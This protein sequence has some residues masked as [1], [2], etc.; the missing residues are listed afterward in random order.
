MMLHCTQLDFLFIYWKTFWIL[1]VFSNCEYCKHSFEGSCVN[2]I[3]LFYW[4][5]TIAILY[6]CCCCKELTHWK[7]PWCWER[8]KAGGEGDDRDD[9]GWDGWMASPTQWTWVWASSGSWWWTGQPG[10]LQSMGWQRVRHDWVAELNWTDIVFI[11][12][13]L[14][15]CIFIL[16]SVFNFKF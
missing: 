4:V 9:R 13:D 16:F 1:P 15:L 14:C 3:Y 10:V 11:L 12:L 5:D 6:D 8:L 2:I 7:R